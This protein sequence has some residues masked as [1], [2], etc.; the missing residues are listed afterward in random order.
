MIEI[1]EFTYVVDRLERH[2]SVLESLLKNKSKNEYFWRLSPKKWC[3]L[4]IV[5]HLFDEE[6]EDFYFDFEKMNLR[7]YKI[8]SP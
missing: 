8:E 3:L 4:E 7:W 6:C 1:M 2:I 5:C